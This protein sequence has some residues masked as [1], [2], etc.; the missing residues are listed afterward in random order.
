MSFQR[1]A[2]GDPAPADEDQVDAKE[3]AEHEEGG[4]RPLRDDHQAE[5]DAEDA[6]ERHP[7]PWRPLSHPRREEDA[8]EA[9]DVDPADYVYQFRGDDIDEAEEEVTGPATVTLMSSGGNG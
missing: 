8:D 3:D 9:A 6:R 2:D 5:Q 4:G 7:A 1:Q